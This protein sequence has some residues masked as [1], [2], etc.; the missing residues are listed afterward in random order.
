MSRPEHGTRLTPGEDPL[1]VAISA[2]EAPGAGADQEDSI[3]QYMA[4]LLKRVSGLTALAQGEQ[5]EWGQPS[6]CNH[7]AQPPVPAR[8]PTARVGHAGVTASP[9]VAPALK[10]V[11]DPGK[12]RSPES[13]DSVSAMRGLA[14]LNAHLAIQ[15]HSVRQLAGDARR[16]L[17]FAAATMLASFLFLRTADAGRPLGCVVASATTLVAAACCWQYF[18]ILREMARR[19]VTGGE[20]SPAKTSDNDPTVARQ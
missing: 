7:Q 4:A 1:G 2:D 19:S 8:S 17:R 3:E 9:A 14:N 10:P 5:P 18:R 13:V 16:T 11:R 6:G 12:K 20:E 15:T